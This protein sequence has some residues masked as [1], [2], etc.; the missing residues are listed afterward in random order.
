[1]QTVMRLWGLLLLC[2]LSAFSWADPLSN[3]GGKHEL[4][5]FN[6]AKN[7]T[8]DLTKQSDQ[9]VLW[10][11]LRRLQSADAGGLENFSAKAQFEWVSQQQSL[12]AN[13]QAFL[14]T[15]DFSQL[16]QGW[17]G[18][19][20]QYVWRGQ[21]GRQTPL[22]LSLTTAIAKRS[23]QLADYD[24]L[25]IDYTSTPGAK[26]CGMQL[27]FQGRL[28]PHDK[29][30]P[31]KSVT[32][33]TGYDSNLKILDMLDT[34]DTTFKPKDYF[35]LLGRFLGLAPDEDWRFVQNQKNAVVQRRMHLKL[36]SAHVL[37]I[38]FAE[39][40]GVERVNLLVSRKDS[41][42]G[43]EL[44][45]FSGLS[46]VATL[47]DGR[48]G[49]RLNL[50]EALAQ[51]FPREWE[52]NSKKAGSNSFYLQEVFL[53]FPGD[54]QTIIKTKPVHRLTVLGFENIQ[55]F[56]TLRSQVMRVN[57]FRQ[58]LMVDIRKFAAMDH[59]DLTQANLNLYS[60]EDSASCM[61]SIN[62]IRAVSI[63][64]SQV[65]VFAENLERWVQSRGGPFVRLLKEQGQV[66]QPGIVNFLPLS[67]FSLVEYSKLKTQKYLP[68]GSQEIAPE[69]KPIKNNAPLPDF[70]V[71]TAAGKEVAFENKRISINNGSTLAFQGMEPTISRDGDSLV[72]KG[73]S[74]SL[75]VTW[76]V[77]TRLSENAWFYFGVTEGAE[78]IAYVSLTAEFADGHQ[79]LRR[80][81]PNRPFRLDS[82]SAQLSKLRLSLAFKTMPF[83]IKFRELALFSPKIATYGEARTL[84]LPLAVNVKPEPILT[85]GTQI[86][87][88]SGP[89]YATGILGNEPVRFVTLLDKQLDWV[90]GFNLGYRFPLELADDGKCP[91]TMQLNWTNGQTLRQFCPTNM[92]GSIFLPLA[93]LLGSE[94]QGRNLGALKSI[95]WIVAASESR[96]GGG[97]EAFSLSFSIEGL[98]MVSAMDQV[99]L[100]PV[101]RAGKEEVY[102]NMPKLGNALSDSYSKR[103]W[104]P[105]GNA[106]LENIAAIKGDIPP[107]NHPLFKIIKVVAEPKQP[108]DTARWLT[109][110]DPPAPK[111]PPRWPKL[112]IWG[113]VMAFVWAAWKKGW[114]SISGLGS[115]SMGIGK[116]FFGLARIAIQMQMRLLLLPWLNLMVGVL[117]LGPGLWVAG[118]LGASIQGGMVLSG[119]LFVILGVYSHW[120]GATYRFLHEKGGFVLALSA[121]CAIWSL[122]HFGLKRDA[123]FGLLPL[124]GA[125][126][127]LLPLLYQ[128][129]L[130]WWQHK[131]HH[132]LL[133]VWAALT[134]ALYGT[135]LNLKMGSG[136][137]YFLTFGGMAVVMGVR[138][139]FL[140]AET[141][142][143]KAFP[144]IANPVYGGAG[145]LYFSGALVMLVGTATLLSLKLE[146]IAEQLAVAVY[147]CLVD[148]TVLEKVALRR[149]QH[150]HSG[151]TPAQFP[152]PVKID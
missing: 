128:R 7:Q 127:A 13:A 147:Y 39:G 60:P 17:A 70:R 59:V 113:S 10:K 96:V 40:I 63:Y 36:D 2:G 82:H 114:W 29:K 85:E 23:F 21:L 48:P 44:L 75:E 146:P 61:V 43:G 69:I 144:D 66:E 74:D 46:P 50:S 79:I 26:Q 99:R 126:Y 88:E 110:L 135:G 62:D 67:I 122:G 51:R 107:V 117:V 83:Q 86:L 14:W 133:A 102:A 73:E 11:G 35:Y 64:N 12:A 131:R 100:S 95:E 141:R 118:R 148:G 116:V 72:L 76:P 78:K 145:S 77:A 84:T 92:K 143:R 80:I 90:Q 105:L 139:L 28:Q 132:F 30:K 119:L 56:S 98:S 91:L 81:E 22:S 106:A 120:R 9:H 54:A 87:M 52:E 55:V 89:G 27:E 4:I 24:E 15:T 149:N 94:N 20:G 18:Q 121:G 104:L 137:N 109:L 71:L 58:R 111:S 45:E 151:G 68:S 134:L 129:L 124:M 41:H 136:E 25:W 101:I 140:V 123:A 1:M 112:L 150:D 6:A 19:G 3:D 38:P 57:T 47:P 32:W 31:P 93:N 130:L 16:A 37:E 49:V 8:A 115:I 53:Y 33:N 108:L 5:L 138:E 65:P 152:P 125:S 103:F 97:Q 34:S 42:G 142:F